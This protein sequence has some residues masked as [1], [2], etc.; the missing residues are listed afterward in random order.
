MSTQIY[1]F[2]MLDD[3]V[4]AQPQNPATIK[5]DTNLDEIELSTGGKKAR[6]RANLAAITTLKQLE[7]GAVASPQSTKTLARYVRLGWTDRGI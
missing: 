5:K 7:S 2:D 4:E 1:M 3:P 6:F